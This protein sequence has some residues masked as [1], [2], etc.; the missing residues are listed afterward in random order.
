[1]LVDP[2][3]PRTS[4]CSHLRNGCLQRKRS[5]NYLSPALD[6]GDDRAAKEQGHNTVGRVPAA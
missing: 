2:A 6:R 3:S 5:P 1:M 4:W